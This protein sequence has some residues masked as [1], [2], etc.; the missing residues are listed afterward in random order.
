MCGN[1]CQ[2]EGGSEF[3]VGQM[4][5]DFELEAYYK[6]E[7]KRYGLSQFRGKWVVLFFYPQDFTFICPTEIKEFSSK[8]SE[9]EQLNAVV[10]GASTDSLHSHKAWAERDFVD[11][12]AYPILSDPT[13]RLSEDYGVYVEEDGVALRGTFIIDPEGVLQWQ[14]VHALSVGRNVG[15]VKRVLEALQTGELCGVNWE[16]GKQT[17]GKA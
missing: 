5:P 13:H 3:Q 6:G 1:H 4:A 17:L 16:S 7:F 15:E 14:C 9:F 8:H 10:L 12:L 2:C 11:G